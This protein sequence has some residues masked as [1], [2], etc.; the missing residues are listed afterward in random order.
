MNNSGLQIGIETQ[1]AL[2]LQVYFAAADITKVESL[3]KGLV[4]L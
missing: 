2:S 3:A 1:I 4:T